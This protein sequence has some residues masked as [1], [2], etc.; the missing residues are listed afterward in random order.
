MRSRNG[1]DLVA[2]RRERAGGHRAPARPRYQRAAGRR[3]D[4]GRAPQPGEAAERSLTRRT[5]WA[6]VHGGF[7]EDTGT[8]DAP[9]ARHPRDR[10]RMAI[11][12]GGRE[13][14]T[15]FRVV[16]RLNGATVLEV[17]LQTGRPTRYGCT[18]PRSAIRSSAT[19]SMAAPTRISGAPRSTR[20]GSA[21]ATP[22]DGSERSYDSPVPDELIA[23][24][25]GSDRCS[26]ERQ[27]EA[28]RADRAERR[29]QGHRAPRAVHPRPVARVL[30]LVHDPPARPGEIEGVS[31]FFVDEEAFRAMI[32][33]GEFFEWSTVYGE[34]KGR[35]F[36]TVNR[37]LASG[38]DTVIKIDVQGPRRCAPERETTV[39]TSSYCPRASTHS[40]S[41]SS[42][43]DRGPGE[44]PLTPR[45]RGR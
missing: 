20:C 3:Q 17:S 40:N 12:E 14:I 38:K 42:S 39:S 30:R 11:V 36:E 21:Y 32:D 25:T 15:D 9:I 8:I 6:L 31:Y 34:L 4:R 22:R 37:S 28:D 10:R 18:S 45:T 7:R 16:E 43:E 23:P 44:P 26:Y 41:G 5:Y 29:R 2:P 35:T 19:A 27:R 33:R 13:A 1:D 24:P